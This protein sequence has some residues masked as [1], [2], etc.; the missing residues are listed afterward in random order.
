[1]NNRNEL[2]ATSNKLKGNKD[3]KGSLLA[4]RYLLLFL[5]VAGYWL[6]VADSF[7]AVITA[8]QLEYFKEEGKYVGTGN[9]RIE[10]DQAVLRADKAV[11]YEKTSDAEA[12]GH[13]VY[14]DEKTLIHAERVELN[15]DTRT[16]KL[17]NAL[18]FLKD[19]KA[20]KT[21]RNAQGAKERVGYWIKAEN[22]MKIK[23]DHY[24]ATSAT[25]T[26]CNAKAY[27]EADLQAA[28]D[29]NIFAAG[30]P[31]WCFKGD[32]VDL[33]VGKKFTAS[34]VTYRVKGLPVLY[35]PYL[36]APVKTERETGFLVPMV[37]NSNTKG[38]QFSPSF[39]WAIDENKD[40]TLSLD[41]YSKRGIGTGAEYR[42]LDFDD[43]GKWYLYRLHDRELG[44][45]FYEFKGAHE[46][47]IGDIRAFADINYVNEVDFYQ[48]YAYRRDLRIQ[49]FLQSTG[50]VSL[51]LRNSRLY[52]LGQY[53]VDLENKDAHVP[54]RLPELGYVVNTSKAGPFMFSM[55]SSVANFTRTTEPSG[56]RADINPTLSYS[57]GSW[58][59]L[60]QSVSLRE[61]A[62]NL[63]N[64]APFN[65]TPH[66]ETFEYRAN[67]LTRF[68]KQYGSA[69]HIIEPSISY[70]FI[71]QTSS[72]PLF[73]STELLNKN[74]L[75]QLS[76]LNALTMHN[77]SLSARVT[78][79]YDFNAVAP[80]RTLQPTI[81][82]L[83]VGRGP[84][85]MNISMSEDLNTTRTETFNSSMSAQ[86][87]R[88]T[89]VT[90]G[91]YT[92]R[93][94]NIMQYNAGLSSI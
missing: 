67:A 76:V 48:E 39:F 71:P 46:H 2:R 5:M 29:E 65:M 60:F 43:R 90:F 80:A 12:S 61:T 91:L 51:P 74:S 47:Q 16:G 66:R 78:Q 15:L 92:A 11:L 33:L 40:A 32:N 79:P 1:M 70:S 41:Y 36:W 8:D 89:S 93:A 52:L 4:T 30:S 31:D 23:E 84:L 21:T 88:D 57:F 87:V 72:L 81:L 25:F 19:Q 7:A 34:N 24:Y 68:F 55:A 22:V 50:E 73:D 6:T 42:Y 3:P 9:V 75:L 10:K 13:I 20:L 56:Q 69:T 62:Y 83:N 64:P 18:I 28:F 38:F 35:S 37:G 14:E 63:R 17:Y 45:T 85:N 77:F 86:I 49:R 26:T 59:Q 53:W 58:A 94:S 27:T 82:E 44:K 54:Q